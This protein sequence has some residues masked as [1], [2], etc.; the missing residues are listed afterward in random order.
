MAE[1][2]SS[3]L[4]NSNSKRVTRGKVTFDPE[5]PNAPVTLVV[6]DKTPN[7]NPLFSTTTTTTFTQGTDGL[8]KNSNGESWLGDYS[9]EGGKV[10]ALMGK[11]IND[12]KVD[13]ETKK[14]WGTNA[15]G[16]D[17]Q[18]EGNA[19]GA[20][21]NDEDEGLSFNMKKDTFKNIKSS[22]SK[23]F[24][25][26]RYPEAILDGQDYCKITQY[27]YVP[28][29]LDKSTGRPNDRM[30]QIMGNVILP[31]PPGLSDGNQVSWAN[32]DMNDLQ[33]AGGAAA[34]RIMNSDKP[35][36][37]IGAEV[38]KFLED[39]RT[40]ENLA[41]LAKTWAMGNLPGINAITNQLLARGSGAIINPNTEV[42]FGGPQIRS[43][44]YSFRMTPRSSKEASSC[45]KIIRF[46]KQGM[47]VQ[48]STDGGMFL[49]SPNVFHVQFY[50]DKGAEHP[51]I[52]KLKKAACT[53][54][55]VNYVPDG[56]YMTL[57]DSS[58]TAYEIG[59]SLM[60]L[61]PIYESD[62]EEA[63]NVGF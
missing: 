54:F 63:S 14:D 12:S 40:N 17:K 1:T 7:K 44:N 27:K 43:F 41:P 15:T 3:L 46:F 33:M 20:D 8:F 49:V 11:K 42:L 61:E 45:Q 10:R 34:M 9:G 25:N 28:G 38:G 16:L 53:G 57:P 50:N 55:T 23:N 59:I 31:I 51:F 39:A 13:N 22:A 21:G 60:E 29:K 24:G 35:L 6:T 4:L 58:M 56:T 18:D 52:G 36:G 32:H 19:G 30:K 26:L 62:Y 2:T 37:D 48:E 5:N 47:A